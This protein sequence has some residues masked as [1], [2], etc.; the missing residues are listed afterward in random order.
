MRI[1]ILYK[2]EWLTRQRRVRKK[3][4]DK[5]FLVLPTPF[6]KVGIGVDGTVTA[7]QTLN[8]PGII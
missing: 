1:I 3:P 8:H 4:I 6:K 5:T 2:E 7:Q